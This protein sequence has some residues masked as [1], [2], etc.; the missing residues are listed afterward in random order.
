MSTIYIVA[1]DE[2]IRLLDTINTSIRLT[3]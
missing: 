3:Y 2:N 1:S